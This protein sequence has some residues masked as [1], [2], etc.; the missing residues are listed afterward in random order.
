MT[1]FKK[2]DLVFGAKGPKPGTN[3]EYV[4]VSDKSIALNP[5]NMT[6][7]EAAAV[8]DTACTTLTGLKEK[9]SIRPT[10]SDWHPVDD[11]CDRNFDFLITKGIRNTILWCLKYKLQKNL[12]PLMSYGN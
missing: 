7:E 3:A 12:F 10:I 6:H 1:K 5:S 8:P 4:C 11:F 2:G 9:V